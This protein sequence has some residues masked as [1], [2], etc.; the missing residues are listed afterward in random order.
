MR[1]PGIGLKS[2]AAILAARR[3]NKLQELSDLRQLG[4]N[5]SRAAPFI[6]LNGKKP[7]YQLG[8]L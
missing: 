7:A 3:Q 5:A 4:I 1:I 6:L 2:A 8:F